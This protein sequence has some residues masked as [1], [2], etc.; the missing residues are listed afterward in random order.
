MYI[1]HAR[2][3]YDKFLSIYWICGSNTL[4]SASSARQQEIFGGRNFRGN[5][6]SRAGV[7]SRKLRKFPAIRCWRQ[8]SYICSCSFLHASNCLQI[9]FT[10]HSLLH[11]PLPDFISQPWRKIRRRPGS[12]IV[13]DRKWWTR[14]VHNVNSVCTNQVHHFQFVT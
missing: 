1:I 5:K 8:C 12:L 13:M 3:F 14:L 6:F 4:C 9:V 7:W 2:W 11:R 10:E